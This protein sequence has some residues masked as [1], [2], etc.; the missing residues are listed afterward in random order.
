ME[1]VKKII[2]PIVGASLLLSGCNFLDGLSFSDKKDSENI[3][4][5]NEQGNGTGSLGQQNGG[6]QNTDSDIATDGLAL[7][8]QYFNNVEVVDGRKVIQ[9][10]LNQLALV[11]KDYAL[12]AYY[13]PED[14]VIPNVTF[15]FGN[16]DIEKAYLRKEAAEKLE[17]MFTAAKLDGIDLFAVSGYRSYKRQEDLF[18]FEV[19]K[20]GREQAE[21]AVAFPGNSEHQ[22]GL[23]MDIS[24]PSVN[25]E[26]T[27]DFGEQPEGQWLEKNAHKYGFILRYPEGKEDIT[28]YKY[29]PWH[30]RYVGE[31]AAAVIYEKDLTLEEYFNI[32]Q[33]I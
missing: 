14:L 7:E 24:G 4:H 18:N 10:P 26:L 29:E 23:A 6:Q 9:N 2:I 5:V 33:K 25:Y 16:Q 1:V 32:V 22:S 17:V 11:N 13:V 15:S 3:G 19:I 31:E 30:F 20:V 8:A 21:L 12:P 28:G 27:Q